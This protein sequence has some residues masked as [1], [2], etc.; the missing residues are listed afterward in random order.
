MIIWKFHT[1][2]F[3]YP[4]NIISFYTHTR[5]CL[6]FEHRVRNNDICSVYQYNILCVQAS[7]CPYKGSLRSVGGQRERQWRQCQVSIFKNSVYSYLCLHAPRISRIGH[8]LQRIQLTTA[9]CL[10]FHA[11]YSQAFMCLV[12][13]SYK[14]IQSFMNYMLED[15]NQIRSDGFFVWTYCIF[16]IHLTKS[17]IKHNIVSYCL[18][19]PCGVYL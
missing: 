17:L 16:H 11:E 6:W 8:L 12:N 9:S 13:V 2:S 5:G 4:C 10:L 15:R 3:T 1:Y 18:K 14:T 7:G 19:V